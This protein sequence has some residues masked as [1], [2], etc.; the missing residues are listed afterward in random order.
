MY[1]K[2]RLTFFPPLQAV[3]AVQVIQKVPGGQEVPAGVQGC[4]RRHRD[5]LEIGSIQL[6][7]RQNEYENIKYFKEIEFNKDHPE[8]DGRSDV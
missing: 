2:R 3:G 7:H 1:L 5:F 6:C 8:N 4:C